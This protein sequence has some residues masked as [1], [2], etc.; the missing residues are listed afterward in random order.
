[1]IIIIIS[2]VV[3]CCI[4]AL[5]IAG[6]GVNNRNR[7]YPSETGRHKRESVDTMKWFLCCLVI[8][9][10]GLGLLVGLYSGITIH[11]VQSAIDDYNRTNLLIL[12]DIEE[13]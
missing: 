7:Y 13:E 2:L 9:F 11:V 4:F 3:L 6:M 5:I 8:I 12:Y 1:M 10:F